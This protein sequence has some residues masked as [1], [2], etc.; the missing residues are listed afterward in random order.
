[1]TQAHMKVRPQQL[2][3]AITSK[4]VHLSKQAREL[5]KKKD[6]SKSKRFKMKKKVGGSSITG[7]TKTIEI[8]NNPSMKSQRQNKLPRVVVTRDH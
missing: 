2:N 7:K 8:K 5:P 6:A 4:K 3:D 1:M